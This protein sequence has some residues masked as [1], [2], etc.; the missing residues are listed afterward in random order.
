MKRKARFFAVGE[1]AAQIPK[2]Q[3]MRYYAGKKVNAA[4]LWSW[5]PALLFL[6][7][8]RYAQPHAVSDSFVAFVGDFA[9][10][11]PAE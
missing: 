2:P 7:E 9:A 10:Y 4:A 11:R 6:L 8:I 1:F 5:I 3:K